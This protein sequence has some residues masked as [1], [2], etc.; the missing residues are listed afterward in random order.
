MLF[1]ASSSSGKAVQPVIAT[2]LIRLFEHVKAIA[3]YQIRAGASDRTKQG[4]SCNQYSGQIVCPCPV[5]HPPCTSLMFPDWSCS[6]WNSKDF[7][8]NHNLSLI[9]SHWKSTEIQSQSHHLMLWAHFLA[10]F[11]YENIYG[12]MDMC[13]KTSQNP[14]GNI[15]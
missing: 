14:L 15:P 9:L 4:G 13:V 11:E 10:V 2:P 8:T 12:K 1:E 6:S 7:I 5:Y 3:V